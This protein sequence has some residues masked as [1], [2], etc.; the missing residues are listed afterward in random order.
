MQ[1]DRQNFQS[2]N[3]RMMTFRPLF[4]L[5]PLN[6]SNRSPKSSHYYFDSKYE[7]EVRKRAK[8]SLL[9]LI[10]GHK[11]TESSVRT[12]HELQSIGRCFLLSR[13]LANCDNVSL[14]NDLR[15]QGGFVKI[16]PLLTSKEDGCNATET[17][18]DVARSLLTLAS[19]FF[20]AVFF[21]L[22]FA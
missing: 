19:V 15:N 18:G 20:F 14:S 17:L 1:Y 8:F 11:I 16:L 2:V 12:S 21:F 6:K 3:S 5:L 9:F 4:V 10:S 13:C 22:V 7:E